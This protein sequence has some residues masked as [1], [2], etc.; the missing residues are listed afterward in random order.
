MS[1][2]KGEAIMMKMIH[3]NVKLIHNDNDNDNDNTF[4]TLPQ[5]HNTMPTKG[6]FFL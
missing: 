3:D 6:T 5:P 4:K 1:I 2:R